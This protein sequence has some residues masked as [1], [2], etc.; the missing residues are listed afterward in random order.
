MKTENPFLANQNN[1]FVFSAALND[2]NS[3]FQSSPLIVPT[4]Y[5]IARRSLQIPNLYY[6]IGQ[7]NQ[8][9]V[10]AVLQQD[11]ILSLS[12]K[13]ENIIP[14][15]QY[16]NNKVAITTNE[17]PNTAGIYAIKN[18]TITLESVSYN[19]NRQESDLNYLDLSAQ[20]TIITQRIHNTAFRYLKK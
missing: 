17:M 19:Y 9:D 8:Y 1:V 15:Q 6:T 3:N 12:N 14:Q 16:F 4:L 20:S 2:Q 18:K 5:N 13:D 11:D 7:T 10:S